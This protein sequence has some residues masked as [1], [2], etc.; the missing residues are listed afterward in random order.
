MGVTKAALIAVGTVGGLGAVLAYQPPHQTSSFGA[1]GFKGSGGVPKTTPAATDTPAATPTETA[2]PTPSATPT[3]EKTPA[4]KAT[5]PAPKAT[6]ATP[7]P[8]PKKTKPAKAAAVNGTFAGAVSKTVYGPVQVQIKVVNNKIVD[9]T[10]LQL[11]TAQP[12]D[13]QLN[14]SSVPLLISQ[15]LAAQSSDIQGV[16]GASYT[17]Q[18]WYDSLVSALAK[19]G[20]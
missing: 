11:P 5:T 14:E 15:T 10:A 18:G 13:I 6:K 3:K 16:S 2:A 4:A 12:Y 20:L 7:K 9:V 17:S 1:G 8:A 19:A